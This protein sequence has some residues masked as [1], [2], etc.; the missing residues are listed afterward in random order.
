MYTNLTSLIEKYE[1]TGLPLH[2][3]L[4]ILVDTSQGLQYLHS[5]DVIHRDLSSN[6]ILLTKHMVAKIADFGMAKMVS[7]N[8]SKYTQAP[9]T[10]PF[11]SPEA[12]SVTLKYGKPLDVFSLG[13]VSIHVI[14]MQWPLPADQ[15]VIN[16]ITGRK[17]TRSEEERR[18]GY[19]AKMIDGS[20]LRGL[21]VQCLQDLPD[22]RP[23]I[24]V[25]TQ[26]LQ[27]EWKRIKLIPTDQ[28]KH[29]DDNILDLL[30][31]LSEQE[32]LVS[33]GQCQIIEKHK[34]ITELHKECDV[35]RT[36]LDN[37]TKQLDI[38]NKQFQTYKENMEAQLQEAFQ[39][40]QLSQ[41]QVAKS[42]NEVKCVREQLNSEYQKIIGD[43]KKHARQLAV[44]CDKLIKERDACK[45]KVEQEKDDA[46][47]YP[48][49]TAQQQNT[50][51][52]KFYKNSFSADNT[53]NDTVSKPNAGYVGFETV[54]SSKTL[55]PRSNIFSSTTNTTAALTTG[56][57]IVTNNDSPSVYSKKPSDLPSTRGSNDRYSPSAITDKGT[58]TCTTSCTEGSNWTH[59][60]MSLL[61]LILLQRG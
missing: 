20:P 59:S 30:T 55:A 58:A 3:K 25:V 21:A 40:L 45:Q 10:L 13:C 11:M 53:I 50:Q 18:E 16:E 54:P 41:Q 17:V 15:V 4:S 29:A 48:H 44:E 32:Q 56:T 34:Q 60:K 38:C 22:H 31:C 46:Q 5:Q 47:A 7:P 52:T 36:K 37:K 27:C 1:T 12:L 39:Q 42:N 14:S 43:L 28:V 49:T 23:T 33:D 9:G 57:T 51:P 24:D 6:N 35:L 19:L 61:P 2:I 8:F 26:E